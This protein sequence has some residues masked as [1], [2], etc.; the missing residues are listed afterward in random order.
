M[1]CIT[2]QAIA[3]LLPAV[4][5]LDCHMTGAAEPDVQG[6][7]QVQPSYPLFGLVGVEP[8]EKSDKRALSAL[9]PQV[10]SPLRAYAGV[11]GGPAPVLRHH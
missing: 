6:V 10:F 2:L 7:Q 5:L 8:A 3:L 11:Y 9:A 4:V 1:Y